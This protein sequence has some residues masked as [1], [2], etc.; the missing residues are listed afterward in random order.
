MTETL[1]NISIP[2]LAAAAVI[3][4]LPAAYLFWSQ[5]LGNQVVLASAVLFGFLILL[6]ERDA[7]TLR[8]PNVLTLPLIALGLMVTWW[9][10]SS[11]LIQHLIAAA[12]GYVAIYLLSELYFR[13]RGVEGIGLGDAKLFA[14]SGAWL[15]LYA[16]PSVLLWA[17]IGGLSVF[18][19]RA[20]TKPSTGADRKIPLGPFLAFGT[21][22]V[23]LYGPLA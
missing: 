17:S 11:S 19:W 3:F 23:W 8:L 12:A 10:G 15:G 21:W 4:A 1:R 6:S 16:L 14:A 7:S 2:V 18:A 13:W 9:L 20:L 22:I 5:S